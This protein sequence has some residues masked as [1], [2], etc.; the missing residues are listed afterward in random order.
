ME[1]GTCSTAASAGE[2]M[3]PFVGIEL[4][5][6]CVPSGTDTIDLGYL[7]FHGWMQA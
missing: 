4:A 6:V 1:S 3:L 7:L 5:S 2:S